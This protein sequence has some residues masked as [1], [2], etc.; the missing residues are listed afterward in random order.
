[1]IIPA[2]NLGFIGEPGKEWAQLGGPNFPSYCPIT[3]YLVISGLGT[4]I[5]L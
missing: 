5:T 3:S 2:L 4:A 1:M